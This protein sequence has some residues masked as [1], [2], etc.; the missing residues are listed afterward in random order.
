V[1]CVCHGFTPKEILWR[2]QVRHVLGRHYSIGSYR[3]QTICRPLQLEWRGKSRA[4][5]FKLFAKSPDSAVTYDPDANDPNTAVMGG[6]ALLS[7]A[8]FPPGAHE[9]VVA[10]AHLRIRGSNPS[11]DQ[12]KAFLADILKDRRPNILLMVQAAFIHES[13]LKQF[14]AGAQHRTSFL[15]NEKRHNDVRKKEL[16]RT[17]GVAATDADQPDCRLSFVWPFDPPGFPK[18]AFDFGVGISQYTQLRTQNITEQIAWNW[19]ENIKVGVNLFLAKLG[20]ALAEPKPA[21]KRGRKRKMKKTR[22]KGAAAEVSTGES[23][24]NRPIRWIDWAMD[25]WSS[26]NG[27]RPYAERLRKTEE[28]VQIAA[29]EREIDRSTALAQLAPVSLQV[30]RRT[31]KPWPR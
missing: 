19:R 4:P 5:S 10:H 20:K 2:L 26:Y 3:Y 14:E 28:G 6:Y 21:E 22:A 23:T 24:A 12:V 15:I 7:V 9:P 17:P 8:A 18:V 27:S 16:K 13:G 30:L 1:K 25:G 29:A 11:P 31:T